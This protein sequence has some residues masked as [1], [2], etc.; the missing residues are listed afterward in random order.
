VGEDMNETDRHS[1]TRWAIDLKWMQLNNR[2][3]SVLARDA[4]CPKCQKKLKV[5]VSEAKAADLLKAT[6]SCCSRAQDFIKSN[7]PVQESIFRIFLA[8]G[9]QPL[10]LDEVNERL[11]QRRGPDAYKGSSIILR[12]LLLNDRHYG[13]RPVQS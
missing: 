2:S 9:N 12:R 1:E 10:T 13:L 4:L 3:L 11:S 5:D 6:Q 8:N 7:L